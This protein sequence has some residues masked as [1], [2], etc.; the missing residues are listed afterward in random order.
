LKFRMNRPLFEPVSTARHIAH[1]AS[2]DIL[3]KSRIA[4]ASTM[5]ASVRKLKDFIKAPPQGLAPPVAI[6]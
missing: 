3:L 6:P 1:C 2:T 5:N 4:T